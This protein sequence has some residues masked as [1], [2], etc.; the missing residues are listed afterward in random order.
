MPVTEEAGIKMAE[1][2]IRCFI[3]LDLPERNKEELRPMIGKLAE[4]NRGIKWVKPENLHFTL[5]F[6]GHIDPDRLAGLEGACQ[7]VAAGTEPF[8]LALGGLGFFPGP[9]SPRVV[10]LGLTG[11]EKEVKEIARKI[12]DEIAA[13]FPPESR[14]FEAHLTLGRVRE[15]TRESFSG[16]GDMDRAKTSPSKIE[17]VVIKQSILK[18][19]GPV[20]KVLKEYVLGT[21]RK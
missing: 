5:K 1:E 4:K 10:W 13:Q 9:T 17:K 12:Q 8:D 7:K 15:R 20:Y 3:A 2:K 6:L 11:G 18:P 19:D 21:A 14:P 16:P